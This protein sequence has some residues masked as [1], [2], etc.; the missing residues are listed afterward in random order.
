MLISGLAVA[1]GLS[2]LLIVP[3]PFVRSLGFAGLVVPVVS[4]VSALSLQPAMLSILG[5]PGITSLRPGGKTAG[6]A[7]RRPLWARL[8][9]IVIASTGRGPHRHARCARR[10]RRAAGMAPAHPWLAQRHPSKHPVGPRGL[11]VLGDRVGP[12]VLTPIEIVLD[13][14]TAGRARS[15]AVYGATLRLARELLKDP[16][17]FV[18]AIGTRSPYLDSSG[19]YD[20]VL[21]VGRHDFGQPATQNLVHQL[22]DR[23]IP[24]GSLA[25]VASCLCW[26]GPG[27]GGRLP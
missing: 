23:S 17:V 13:T 18:V 14:T 5:R 9:D 24:A 4:I 1:S 6:A 22:E 19:R 16:E 25:L 20:R 2:A 12:G 26:R 27:P 15:P 11:K 7:T 10:G 21:V 8:S 3:V